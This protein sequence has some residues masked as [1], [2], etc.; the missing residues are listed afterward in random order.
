MISTSF[1]W[2]LKTRLVT[3][4]STL[5][6]K[7]KCDDCGVLIKGKKIK[8][9]YLYGKQFCRK[10]C[11]NGNYIVDCLMDFENG[12]DIDLFYPVFL[13]FYNDRKTKLK[14]GKVK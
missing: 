4:L 11:A 1:E 5:C 14:T 13:P 12:K 10:G 3:V 2:S 9:K 8:T 6:A 7:N